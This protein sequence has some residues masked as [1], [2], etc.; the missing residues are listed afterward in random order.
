MSDVRR[1]LVT[2]PIWSLCH[3]DYRAAGVRFG[4]E[5]EPRFHVGGYGDKRRHNKVC[6]L[7]SVLTYDWSAA[8]KVHPFGLSAVVVRIIAVKRKLGHDK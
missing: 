2:L 3:T 8:F 7:R 5:R 4:A 1:R 6:M